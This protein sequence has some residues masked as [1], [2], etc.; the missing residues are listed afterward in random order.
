MVGIDKHQRKYATKG[1]GAQDKE[2][3]NEISNFAGFGRS[4]I[5]LVQ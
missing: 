5:L 1:T 2:R 4:V 3:K